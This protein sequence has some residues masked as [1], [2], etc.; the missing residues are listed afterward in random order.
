MRELMGI[1]S[2][3]KARDPFRLYIRFLKKILANAS[4]ADTISPSQQRFVK[5]IIDYYYGNAW[6]Y[7]A[8][9]VSENTVHLSPGDNQDKLLTSIEN[10][11]QEI[12]SDYEGDLNGFE[13]RATALN[14]IGKSENEEVNKTDRN[15]SDSAFVE[16]W[17]QASAEA[18]G[19]DQQKKNNGSD[20][21]AEINR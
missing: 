3:R 17:T 19:E 13:G 21:S 9:M 15:L 12:R 20:D 10:D 18:I 16:P 1:D 7:V 14:I 2:L 5:R 11:K 4:T 6:K 8:L